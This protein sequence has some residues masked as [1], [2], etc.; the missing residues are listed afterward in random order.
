M[1]D[2]PILMECITRNPWQMD[3]ASYLGLVLVGGPAG[4]RIEGFDDTKFAAISFLGA[5]NYKI[6][7]LWDEPLAPINRA[8]TFT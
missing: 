1:R 5:R 3:V 7:V 8:N 4:R 2:I 6:G